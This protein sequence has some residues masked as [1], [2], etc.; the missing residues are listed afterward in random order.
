MTTVSVV[1][2]CYNHGRFL[3]DAIESV[4]RQSWPDV[5]LIV[6]DD[7]STDDSRTVAAGFAEVKLVRQSNEGLS[8]ARNRGL[9]ASSGEIVIFLDAD[10]ILLPGAAEAAVRSLTA[11][12]DAMMTFGRLEYMDAE[13]R[14]LDNPVPRV[15]SNFYEEFLKRNYIRTPAVAAFRRGIFDVAGEFD[16][17]CSPSADYDLYLRISRRFAIAAHEVAVARYRQHPGSMSRNAR[18]MLPATLMVLKR[19][20]P[21]VERAPDL[22]AAYRFGLRRCR[23]FYGEQLVEQFRVALRTPRGGREALACAFDLLR[24]YPRGVVKHL[25]KKTSLALGHD[26]RA[27]PDA[28][29]A[30][31]SSR[32]SV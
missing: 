2:P 13:G 20:R 19:Q 16:P 1:I 5:E 29:T 23:E 32:A 4:R 17:R 10:D 31:P 8:A 7:G 11:Q 28:D 15:T 14:P 25:L 6:V 9:H 22:S 27:R 24:L 21:V 30:A 18:L 26:G 3:R 12:P